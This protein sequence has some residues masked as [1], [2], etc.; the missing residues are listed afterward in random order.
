VPL[1]P[2]LYADD[3]AL[4]Y[5]PSTCLVKMDPERVRDSMLAALHGLDKWA[6]DDRMELNLSKCDGGL[7]SVQQRNA[8]QGGARESAS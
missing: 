6:R 5:A 3:A 1:Q 8:G 4:S 2:L 7:Q